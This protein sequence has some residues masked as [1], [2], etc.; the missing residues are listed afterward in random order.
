MKLRFDDSV[1]AFRAEL[2]A[3]VAEHRPSAEEMA[4][5]PFVSTGHAPDWSRRWTR[6]LFDA[7]LLVPGWPP[8]WGG[9]NLGP[10]ETLVYMEEL[11]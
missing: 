6:K 9:R 8:E 3:W 4:A 10:V 1:E 2:L 5:E 11:A 7:G